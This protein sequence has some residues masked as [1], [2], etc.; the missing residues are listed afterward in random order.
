MWKKY[1][2]IALLILALT[3]CSS[4][5]IPPAENAATQ[6]ETQAQVESRDET[7]GDR[8]EPIVTAP[9]EPYRPLTLSELFS[10]SDGTELQ[11]TFYPPENDGAP[12]IIL[13]HWA[14]GDQ[15]DYAAIADW[16]QNRGGEPEVDKNAQETW[17]DASWFP[18][19]DQD[20]SYGVFTFSFRD[21]EKGCAAF[22]SAEW[23][24]DAQSAVTFA[25]D[26]PYID[27]D[28]IIVIGA[29]IGADG[30][31]DGCLYLNQTAPGSCKGAFSISPGSY[32]TEVYADVVKQLAVPAVCVY[33][34]SDASAVAA[35]A[36][37]QA[38]NYTA[39]KIGSAHGMD[40]IDPQV[41][42]NPLDLILELIRD[43]LK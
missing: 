17:L 31:A 15:S 41:Q 38:D 4:A 9:A 25:R 16:L 24:D 7:P 3:A 11:G 8:Q 33:A 42:P 30:A 19:I 1:W 13:T 28:R 27:P 34:P 5:G 10:A 32:L 12:L 40:L 36:D 14:R 2:L 37:V 22:H 6:S 26:L 18:V 39:Y 43:S 35:C 29:S 23:L 21:C 20:T